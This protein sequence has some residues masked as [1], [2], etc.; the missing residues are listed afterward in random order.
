M[1]SK[2]LFAIFTF[3]LCTFAC[4]DLPLSLEDILTD[5]GKFK[6]ESSLTYANSE[7]N[8]NQFSNP[9]YIQ[10]TNN[11]LVAVPTTLGNT[12]SNSDVIVGTVGLRYRDFVGGTSL[13]AVA[14]GKRGRIAPFGAV[15][16]ADIV[17]DDC[18]FWRVGGVGHA[19]A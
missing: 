5:K 18:V 17:G 11:T 10:T 1:K 9:I 6:L 7:R 19:S 12:D 8:R 16:F 2:I 3:F 15:G 14:M 13:C 4:A